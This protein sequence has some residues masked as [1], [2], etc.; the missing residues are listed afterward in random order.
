LEVRYDPRD[1]S[2]AYVRDQKG[3]SFEPLSGAT[4]T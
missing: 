3:D 2:H 1:I 4:V